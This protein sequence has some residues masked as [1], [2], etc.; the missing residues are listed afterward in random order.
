M[1]QDGPVTK[2]A[3]LRVYAPDASGSSEPVP[4]FVRRYGLLSEDGAEQHRTA[5]WKGSRMVCPSNLRLRVLESTV[6]FASA[7]RGLGVGLVPEVEAA[8]ADR[9][10]RNYHRAHPGDRSHVLTSAWHV[11]VRWFVA[12]D[13]SEKEVYEGDMG[14]RLR[15]RADMSAVTSRIDRAMGILQRLGVFQA[16]AEELGQLASWLTAFDEGSMVELDYDSVSELFDPEEL[17]FDDSCDLIQASLDALERGDLGRA[18]ECYG[19]V[20]ARWAPAFSITFSN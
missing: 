15:Y 16:P 18:G 4:A 2:T 14:P 17:V 12:Y 6:A 8:A 20:V 10:L 5:E 1:C 9:E 11:P 19:R 7:F 13:P 3:C